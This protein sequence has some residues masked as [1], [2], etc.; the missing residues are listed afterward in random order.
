MSAS[1]FGYPIDGSIV[2]IATIIVAFCAIP[3]SA[4]WRWF[5]IL[6]KKTV[7]PVMTWNKAASVFMIASGLVPLAYLILAPFSHAALKDL[8]D[9]SRYTLAIGGFLG[10]QF[11]LREILGYDKS[12]II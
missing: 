8:L 1:V 5:L 6:T 10:F 11:C 9:A 2:D 4:L 7:Y 3:I 12:E